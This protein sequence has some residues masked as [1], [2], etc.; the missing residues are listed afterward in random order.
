M[1]PEATHTTIKTDTMKESDSNPL[2][3]IRKALG[4]PI[5]TSEAKIDDFLARYDADGIDV[6]SLPPHLRPAP[7]ARTVP[8]GQADVSLHPGKTESSDKH[9]PLAIAARNGD[10]PLSEETLKKMMD[11]QDQEEES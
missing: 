2:I 9:E 10:E 1:N 6:P 4:D 3:E 11:A 7:L 5:T 8:G